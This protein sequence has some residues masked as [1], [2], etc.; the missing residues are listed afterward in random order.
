MKRFVSQTTREEKEMSSSETSL[1]L[2]HLNKLFTDIKS[3]APQIGSSQQTNEL[4][5]QKIY[6]ILPLFCKVC[7]F[8][9]IF[10]FGF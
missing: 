8:D 1:A 7:P 9:P 4:F 3:N 2:S 10:D 5:E 6:N